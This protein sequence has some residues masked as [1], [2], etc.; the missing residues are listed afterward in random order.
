MSFLKALGL[1][2]ALVVALLVA[3]RCYGE[4]ESEW[5][6]RVERVQ[7]TAA[8]LRAEVVW[9][10]AVVESLTRENVRLVAGISDRAIVTDTLIIELPPAETPGEVARDEIIVRL[11]G[12][13]DDAIDAFHRQ[14]AATARLNAALGVA[15]AR[16]DSLAAVLEDRPS[17]RPWY[18]PRIGLGP[19]VGTDTQGQVR[20]HVLSVGV[21]W[22]VGI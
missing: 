1:G 2:A 8:Q 4:R 10:R 12:E 6:A 3:G 17:G 5:E 14:V 20:A 9:E 21:F 22:E 11:T 7:A 18:L 15:L 16:G 13:R 19:S